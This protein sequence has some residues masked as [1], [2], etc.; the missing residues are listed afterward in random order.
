MQH[1]KEEKTFVLIKPDGVKKGLIG[2]VIRRFE[3]RDLKVVALEMFQPTRQMIDEHYPKDQ[4]WKERLGNKTLSTYEKYALDPV[5]SLGTAEPLALGEMVRE[6]LVNYMTSAPLVRMVV[7]GVHAV[8]MVRKIAGPTLPYAADMGTIRG[9]F[10][11][12]S[13]AVANAE[14]RAVA[15]ILHASETA[16][17]AEHEIK[18]WFG[19]K[20][21][22]VYKR[23]G[24]DLS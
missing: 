17:E 6:W 19:D 11:V 12:D 5:A 7:Q 14:K 4:V 13:P 10:S 3:Q 18:H 9:D 20:K 1:I 16:A 15:N 24:E 8:D 23:Y 22:H 2:E 21:P